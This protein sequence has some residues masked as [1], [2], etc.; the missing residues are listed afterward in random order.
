VV[1][2]EVL[3]T[4]SL[5]R[6]ADEERPTVLAVV[7]AVCDSVGDLGLDGPGFWLPSSDPHRRA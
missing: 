5:V 3:W 7:D 1:A 2:P 4:W 6:R